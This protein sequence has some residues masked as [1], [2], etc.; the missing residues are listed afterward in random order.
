MA[1]TDPQTN[2]R[3][4]QGLKESLVQAAKESGRSFGAE[5][6]HRLEESFL[7]IEAKML[8]NRLGELTELES[9]VLMH[10]RELDAVISLQGPAHTAKLFKEKL[11]SMTALR[12]AVKKDVAT[13][14]AIQDASAKSE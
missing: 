9:A 4:P 5:V 10:Q 8:A 11:R 14:R 13:L 3:L 7:S 1:R 6:V 12:D 2:I